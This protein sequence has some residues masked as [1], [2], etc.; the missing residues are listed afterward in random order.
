MINRR[1]LE[2]PHLFVELALW[3][4][5]AID[6]GGPWLE[7][8]P[9]SWLT[10]LLDFMII[11]GDLQKEKHH[12][13]TQR[14]WDLWQIYDLV[15]RIQNLGLARRFVL[16]QN[17]DPNVQ[18]TAETMQVWLTVWT[19]LSMSLSSPASGWAYSQLNIFVEFKGTFWFKG[20]N[21]YAMS[22]FQF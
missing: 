18:H 11:Y 3:P 13:N 19:T 10:L 15:Q 9:R 14:I 2:Q 7:K 22:L 21:T 6:G 20:I 5:S 17:N 4:N 8:W 16:Q 12:C 1:S